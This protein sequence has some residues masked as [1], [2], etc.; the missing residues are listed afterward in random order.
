MNKHFNLTIVCSRAREA[1]LPAESGRPAC[2]SISKT[3]G[4]GYGIRKP[5][6][7]KIIGDE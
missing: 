6:V 4:A 2:G 7:E 1:V 3:G 5:H